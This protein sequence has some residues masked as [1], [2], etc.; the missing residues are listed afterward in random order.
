V[1]QLKLRFL[2]QIFGLNQSLMFEYQGT[3]YYFK[4]V[5]L[6]VLDKA[7][8]Q[9]RL[10]VRLESSSLRDPRD[11]WHLEASMHGTDIHSFAVVRISTCI[12]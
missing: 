5:N 11:A 2:L 3:N 1:T 10:E 12:I 9:V 4:V 8:E 6:L 7:G